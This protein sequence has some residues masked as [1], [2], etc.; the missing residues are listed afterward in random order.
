MISIKNVPN[1]LGK[2]VSVS[3]W[4]SNFRSSGKIMFLQLRDGS[5]FMQAV[6]S[7]SLFSDEQWA[8]L[9]KINQEASI[10]LTG[11]V[12]ENTRDDFGFELSVTG[13]EIINHSNEDYPISNKEHGVDF[14]MDHRHLWLRSK[15]QWAILRVRN[16]IINATYEFFNKEGFIKMDS[17]ILTGSACE[18]TTELFEL[19]YFD[20]KAYLSQSGQLYLEAAIFGFGKCFDFGPVFRAEKSKTRRHLTEFWMMDA[21]MAFHDYMDNIKV[22]EALICFIVEK[23]L[24][25]NRKELLILERNVEALEKVQAPFI[26]KTH[27]EVVKELQ[28][29]GSDIK[30][31][32]DMGADDE[33]ILTKKY[34]K[35]IFV[36][37]YPKE[38]KAFYMK[39]DPEDSSRVLCADLLAPE[40][41]GEIIGGSQREDNYDKLVAKIKDHKLDPETFKWYL[42]LRK[43]GSV[44]HSGFG[45]GLERIVTWICGLEHVRE[46]IP[47]ARTISRL[48]P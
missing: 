24:A 48:D 45:Y 29:M 32:D 22:Q 8:D 20:R 41:Y 1:F 34:D 18:G 36:T 4:V 12:Q 21:E 25:D 15:R 47:F 42:D 6:I 37:K 9:E 33:T 16:T 14:L 46:S 17:P 19:D 40:G 5:G 13:F 44:P 43:Y 35:P 3:G 11:T 39:E 23:V 28:E 38:V 27:K 7:K 30:E 31:N 26:I 2:E 10:K